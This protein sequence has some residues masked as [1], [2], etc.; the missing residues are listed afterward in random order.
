NGDLITLWAERDSRGH[1]WAMAIDL[2]S[3]NGC[4]ACVIACNAE[5]NV[6]VV[7]RKEILKSREMHWIR[8]D[9]YYRFRNSERNNITKEKEYN[10]PETGVD[11]ENVAVTFQPMVCQQCNHAPCET[12]C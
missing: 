3:C 10:K 2:N 4:G 5:N 12:V 7:G 1:K 11:F 8:I 9:R 6:P